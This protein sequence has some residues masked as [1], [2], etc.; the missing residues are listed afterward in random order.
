V[1]DPRSPVIA[2]SAM[3]ALNGALF[4]TWAS[5]I[6]DFVERFAIPSGLLGLLL[7]CLAGGA[8][9]SFPLAGALSDRFGA[10]TLT[11][12]M[13][14]FYGVALACLALSPSIWLLTASLLLFGMGHGAM[15]VA[16]NA[17]GAEVERGRGRHLMPMFHAMFSL[18]AGL[19]AASGY[20]ALSAGFGVAPHFLL[21]GGLLTVGAL[22]LASGRWESVRT[23][24]S[25]VAFALPRGHLV[26]VGLI[27]FACSLGEGAMADWS[28]VFLD[29]ATEAS[30]AQA[31]LGYAAFSVTMVVTRL[32]G[33]IL[34]AALGAGRAARISGAFAFV[35]ITIVMLSTQLVPALA[36]FA[37]LGVGY[38]VIMP[39][40]FSRA[41][42][43]PGVGA[44]RAIAGVATLGYGGMLLGPP[45]IGFLAELTSLRLSF[46]LL[47]VL[48]ALSIAF[49]GVLQSRMPAGSARGA[50]PDQSS[51]QPS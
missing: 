16:M 34:I 43:E 35:G 33:G 45:V 27:A 19:G 1:P 30:A 51:P 9:L 47:A 29:R 14:A 8:I 36:G 37:L 12:A 39:L 24:R 18:G 6:P 21:L 32:S 10:A 49:G 50:A 3:F 25:G 28:A 46:L 5:R 38:A 22:G 4:G 2:V 17:W 11:R 48:S 41:A 31:A 44:G 23:P 40:A 26:A 42:A 20:G 13:A 15:D 7:L